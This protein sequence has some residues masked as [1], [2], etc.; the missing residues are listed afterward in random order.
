MQKVSV[1][2]YAKRK[3]KNELIN[4]ICRLKCL[5]FVFENLRLKPV[6]DTC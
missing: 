1:A 6:S 2:V 3:E 4:L 5:R